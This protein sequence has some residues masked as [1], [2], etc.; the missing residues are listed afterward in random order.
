MGKRLV[1][2][3]LSLI[4]PAGFIATAYYLVSMSG[5]LPDVWREPVY[6]APYLVAAIGL[7]LSWRF[8]SS[9]LVFVNVL[10][11]LL[12]W[13]YLEL[14]AQGIGQDPSRKMAYAIISLLLPINIIIFTLL[15]ERGIFTFYGLLRL[16]F[17]TLQA[18]LVA[19]VV[20]SEPASWM[21]VIQS[22]LISSDIL[23]R[24]PLAQ[25]AQFVFVLAFI[26]LVIRQFL[27]PSACV[28]GFTGTLIAVM[29]VLNHPGDALFASVFLGTTAVMLIV[30]VIQNSYGMAYIDELTGLPGRRALKEQMMKFGGQYCAAM[31]DIDRFK[32]IND[33]YGHDVGDQVLH[34]IASRIGRVSGGGKAYRYGGEEF[35]IL[36]S[37]K[38]AD[39]AWDYLEEMREE[40]AINHFVLRGKDRPRRKS[41]KR[42]KRNQ[43]VKKIIITVSVGVADGNARQDRPASVLKAADAA[44]YRAKK[45]GRNRVCE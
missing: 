24:S 9:R 5:E 36:F 33:T 35:T 39:Q 21:T 40:I 27:R 44:L 41:G 15:R 14:F 45:K 1:S 26:F 38:D 42:S 29:I 25:M 32:K 4:I 37:G 18:G 16:I 11:I 17:I 22:E 10:L 8:N 19:W 3:I 20:K 12:Y 6:Y 31:V 13:V 2:L 7:L 34:F 23:K 43:P 28:I 30:A